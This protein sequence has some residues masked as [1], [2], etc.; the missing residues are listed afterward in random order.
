MADA[1][2]AAVRQG[3][4]KTGGR[5]TN[6]RAGGKIGWPNRPRASG[7]AQRFQKALG[8]RIRIELAA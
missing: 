2:E 4:R 1:G 7:L 5:M 6:R 3:I 8:R